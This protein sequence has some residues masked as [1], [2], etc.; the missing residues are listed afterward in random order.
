LFNPVQ[1]MLLITPHVR[2]AAGLD[3][4]SRIRVQSNTFMK[5]QRSV[6]APEDIVS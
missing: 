3:F 5:S 2:A 4:G 6:C 1:F